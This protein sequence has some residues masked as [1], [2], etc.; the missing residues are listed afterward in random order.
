MTFTGWDMSGMWVWALVSG[1]FGLALT[2]G[3]IALVVLGIRWLL[4]QERGAGGGPS[5]PPVDDPLDILRRRYAAGEI[6]EEEYQRRRK[7]LTG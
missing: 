5:S 2:I 6:D 4:R 1:V 7:T 3:L